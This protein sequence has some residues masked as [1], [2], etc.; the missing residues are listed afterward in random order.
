MKK[1]FLS[2]IFVLVLVTSVFGAAYA[3]DTQ[4]TDPAVLKD[5]AAVRRATVKYHDVQVALDDGYLPTPACVSV[6]GVGAM[7]IHYVNPALAMDSA[8][9]LKSPEVLL[10]AP[11]EDG[12]RL[13]GVEYF[14]GLGAPGS[15][16]P[17]DPPPAPVL[18][19]RSFDGPMEGHDPEMPP[20]YDLHVWI[21][22]ANPND[23]FSPLNPNVTCR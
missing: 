10:Y 1:V 11:T 15:P 3:S 12:L 19:G 21:W 17:T 5:L 8:I 20:H 23:M 6:Q 9:V 22:Q 13:V 16:V 14:L 18:F 7:G 2:V 4:T